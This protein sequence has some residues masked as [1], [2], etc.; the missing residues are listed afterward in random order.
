MPLK[1]Q[2]KIDLSRPHG[3]SRYHKKI[4]NTTGNVPALYRMPKALKAALRKEADSLGLS[5]ALWVNIIL[6]H[7]DFAALQKKIKKNDF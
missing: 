7:R 5:E 2:N 6:E 4:Q 3:P 1:N